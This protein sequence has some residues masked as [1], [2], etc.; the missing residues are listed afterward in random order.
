MLLTANLLLVSYLHLFKDRFLGAHRALHSRP[1][2]GHV[3]YTNWTPEIDGLASIQNVWKGKE[4]KGR[5]ALSE[6]KRLQFG[7]VID[8]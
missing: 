8:R 7:K 3:G 1:L 6:K 2:A 4:H 5:L